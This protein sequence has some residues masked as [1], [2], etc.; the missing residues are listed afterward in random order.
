MLEYFSRDPIACKIVEAAPDVVALER[1]R[2]HTVV[3]DEYQDTGV[4]Q[5]VLLSTLFGGG[6]SVT[7]VGD[8]GTANVPA[9]NLLLAAL[10]GKVASG[11]YKIAA[12]QPPGDQ[13]ELNS[14]SVG[15]VGYNQPHGNLQPYQAVNYC[16]AVEG[17]TPP[18]G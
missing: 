17:V 5:R 12:Y 16:I 8:P 13:T 2:F 9:G 7:A 4:A 11:D 18:A 10:G 14:A 3:L 6:H 1:Q 15:T